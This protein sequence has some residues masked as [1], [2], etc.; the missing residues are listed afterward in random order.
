LNLTK[1]E[2]VR[3][4]AD[5]VVQ[6]GLLEAA[7]ESLGEVKEDFFALTGLYPDELGTN[8]FVEVRIKN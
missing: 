4:E 8:P 5:K 7:E 2:L 3:L 1:Q 6:E